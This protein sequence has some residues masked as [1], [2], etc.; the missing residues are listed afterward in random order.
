MEVAERCGGAAEAQVGK[1]G[2]AL[3]G[4]GAGT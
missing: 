2:E 1:G 3:G 4:D